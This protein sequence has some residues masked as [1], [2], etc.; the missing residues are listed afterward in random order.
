MC[1]APGKGFLCRISSSPYSN[2][3]EEPLIKSSLAIWR[4]LRLWSLL[5]LHRQEEGANP[6]LWLQ[7]PGSQPLNTD[8]P[9]GSL[10]P[11]SETGN[12]GV[13]NSALWMK[14]K[15]KHHV[16]W[17]SGMSRVLLYARLL[18][19]SPQSSHK[20]ISISHPKCTEAVSDELTCIGIQRKP[21]L[22]SESVWV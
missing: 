16:H 21:E 3:M 6:A 17:V 13:I 18:T 20:G 11:S 5:S 12:M 22:H 19:W 4:K 1:Q 14:G 7:N 10:L 15:R 9:S 2:A 8:N